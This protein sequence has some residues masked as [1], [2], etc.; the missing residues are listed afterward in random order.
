MRRQ[1]LSVAAVAATYVAIALSVPALY[2]DG[3][4]P[5]SVIT[6]KT[7][8]TDYTQEK[9]GVR[10][11]ITVADLPQPYATKGVDNGA[12]MVKRPDG[13]WPQ[14][15]AGFKVSLYADG[16]NQ[17]RLIRTAPNGDLFVAMSSSNEIMVFRGVGASGK[18]KQMEKFADGLSQPF[19]I[20]FYPSGPDPKWVYIGNTD[21]VVRFPYKNGD[22]KARGSAEKLADLPGG[23]RLRGGGHW[24]RDI[25]FSKDGTKMFV[26]VG[27]HSNVDDPDTHPEEFHRADV[28]EFTPEGK[29][30]KI[31]A[32]GI[33]NC[34]GEAINPTTGQ[35]WCSTNERDMLGDNLV[36]DYV[37]HIEEDGF[38]GWPWWYMGQ[39][40]DP[41][42]QGTHPELKTKVITPDVLLQPHFASLEMNFYE[43]SQFPA[44]YKGDAF[45]A[46]HGSW[47]KANR[48]GYEVIRVPMHDG[49]A[50]GE[51]EDFLTGFTTADGHVWGRPVGVTVAH[52]GSLFV[53]DDGSGSIWHVTY[54]S[55]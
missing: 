37:T 22:L 18:P 34:V 43:G 48:A 32:Y 7:A 52:D 16:L 40:Q 13:A 23:G 51:Y 24:T 39:N 35:L 25:V 49:K 11:K 27:S 3:P 45:A 55:R 6:G 26:S 4:P 30:I 2:A 8:F 31:Y 5:P 15:P 19:G 53:T 38:Y 1:S 47:N 20:A 46:E 28:L 33:R 54:G 41:R 29:F 42:L 21:S 17:P 12:D 50:T 9:P 44:E 14:A 36:P 10:R